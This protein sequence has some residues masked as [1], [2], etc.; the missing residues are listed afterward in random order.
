MCA[1][2]Q[3]RGYAFCRT[4][5]K[6]KGS[7]TASHHRAAPW[8][9]ASNKRQGHPRCPSVR[10]LFFVG[11][12]DVT[13][14]KGSLLKSS[15]SCRTGPNPQ[16]RRQA[17]CDETQPDGAPRK[18]EIS[19]PETKAGTDRVQRA[20]TSSCWICVNTTEEECGQLKQKPG[21]SAGLEPA[22]Q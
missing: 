1:L 5:K 9:M 3:A 14:F 13:Q 6:V 21:G 11:S 20:G 22:W 8:V 18:R 16:A 10:G 4:L 17:L 19:I 12:D 2:I 7:T 15:P